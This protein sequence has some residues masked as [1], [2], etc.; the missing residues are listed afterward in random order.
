MNNSTVKVEY[1]IFRKM[2]PTFLAYISTEVEKLFKNKIATIGNICRDFPI[3]AKQNGH[4]K[5]KF[6]TKSW[7]TQLPTEKKFG[8]L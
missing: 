8:S 6:S 5:A 4:S 2:W 3:V 1:R 7:A